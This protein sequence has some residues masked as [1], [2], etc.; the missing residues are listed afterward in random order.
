L[1]VEIED[2]ESE[3][4]EEEILDALNYS[5]EEFDVNERLTD[6]SAF[7]QTNLMDF[8]YLEEIKEE[9]PMD[10]TTKSS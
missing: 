9:D 5:D 3:I 6:P 2:E 7:N 4:S 10:E 8:P 1:E